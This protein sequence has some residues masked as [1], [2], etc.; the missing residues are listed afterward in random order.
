MAVWDQPVCRDNSLPHHLSALTGSRICLGSPPTGLNRVFQHPDG[1][2]SCVPPS[3]QTLARWYR[4]V[5]L[6]AIAYA[7]RPRLRDRLTLGRLTLPRKPWASGERVFHPL[8][9]YSWQHNLLWDLQC[10]LR[11][12]FTGNHNAPLPLHRTPKGPAKPAASVVCFSPV[13]FSARTH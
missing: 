1:L 6:F 8:Y 10:S 4:N 13:K 12:T 3:V 9:R 7:F 2:P 5:R 11:C